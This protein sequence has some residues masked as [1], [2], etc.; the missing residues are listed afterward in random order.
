MEILQSVW[1]ARKSGVTRS[2]A[3]RVSDDMMRS[4]GAARQEFW[5]PV[6]VTFSTFC[7]AMRLGLSHTQWSGGTVQSSTRTSMAPELGGRCARLR[8]TLLVS[9]AEITSWRS[10]ARTSH[11]IE[12]ST[13]L[14]RKEEAERRRA[15]CAAMLGEKRRSRRTRRGRCRFLVQSPLGGLHRMTSRAQGGPCA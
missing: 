12:A 2:V 1:R 3:Y 7:D 11:P 10:V 13:S 9:T 8:D 4:N 5:M 15:V 14:E 6:S